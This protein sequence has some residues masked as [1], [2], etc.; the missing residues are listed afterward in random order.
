HLMESCLH[1]VGRRGDCRRAYLSERLNG[2]D[3]GQVIGFFA[4]NHPQRLDRTRTPWPERRQGESRFV[5][6]LNILRPQLLGKSVA[7]SVTWRRLSHHPH[8]PCRQKTRRVQ[9]MGSSLKG[10]TQSADCGL[11]VL[12]KHLSDGPSE[13]F[14]QE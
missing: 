3:R 1:Q 4:D 9:F 11:D 6:N 14:L 2:V 13:L 12:A 5:S 7:I 10:M 8:T